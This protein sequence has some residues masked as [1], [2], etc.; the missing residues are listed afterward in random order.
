MVLFPFSD[1]KRNQRSFSQRKC[2]QTEQ[3]GIIIYFITLDIDRI[4]EKVTTLGGDNIL[5]PKTINEK[6]GF[7]VAEFGDSERNRIAIQQIIE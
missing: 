1:K 3:K 6:Y 7:Y 2:L 4:L 5:Y